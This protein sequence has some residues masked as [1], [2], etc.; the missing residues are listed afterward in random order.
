[1]VS[2]FQ[3]VIFFGA[4]SVGG[5]ALSVIISRFNGLDLFNY[6]PRIMNYSKY[7]QFTLVLIIVSGI[8][9]CLGRRGCGTK[10][11]ASLGIIGVPAIIAAMMG[12]GKISMPIPAFFSYLFLMQICDSCVVNFYGCAQL[13]REFQCGI[14]GCE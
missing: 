11:I 1:M 5:F 2:E 3:K 10:V 7:A 8:S 13:V 12:L 4:T 6:L 9:L 14:M